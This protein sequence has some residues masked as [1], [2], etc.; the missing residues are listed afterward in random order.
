MSKFLGIIRQ[1]LGFAPPVSRSVAKERLSLMLVTQ[2]SS[3][4]LDGLDMEAF[5]A[6][7]AT[8]VQKY[9]KIAADKN[10]QIAVKPDGDLDVL[11][12]HFPLE[13]VK[14]RAL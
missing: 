10:P 7:V 9:M 5:Q 1:S 11:E 14:G 4:F 8:V 12:I 13:Y 6:E 3:A 2:R